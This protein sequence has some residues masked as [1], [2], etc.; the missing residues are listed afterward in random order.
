MHKTIDEQG[1]WLA[2]VLRGY[3]AY[4]AVPDNSPSLSAFRQQVKER[5]LRVLRRRSQRSKLT[6]ERMQIIVDR[7]LPRPRVLHPWPEHRFLVSHS[8]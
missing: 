8:T 4:F 1:R 3:F 5:W 2:A 6:Y 7:T